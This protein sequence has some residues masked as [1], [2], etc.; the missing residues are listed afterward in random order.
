MEMEVEEEAYDENILTGSDDIPLNKLIS[1]SKK[2][3]KR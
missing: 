2:K 1:P 3:R